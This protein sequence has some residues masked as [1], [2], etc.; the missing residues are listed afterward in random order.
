MNYR[1][2]IKTNMRLDCSLY[3][4]H[5]FAYWGSLDAEAHF[6]HD[7]LIPCDIGA[8]TVLRSGIEC[9]NLRLIISTCNTIF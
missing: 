2:R 7:T 6:E 3:S 8:K 5:C 1:Y 9:L 4:I